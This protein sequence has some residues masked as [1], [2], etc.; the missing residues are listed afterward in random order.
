MA[1]PRPPAGS[2]AD[3]AM[4]ESRNVSEE[5]VRL[6][7]SG[8]S[9]VAAWNEW[10][11]GNRDVRLNLTGVR[12]AGARLSGAV[13][14]SADLR[15]ADQTGARVTGANLR[16]ADLSQTCLRGAN[17]G[18]SDFHGARLL[19]AD[20][21]EARLRGARFTGADL[22]YAKLGDAFLAGADLGD[23]RLAYANLAGANLAYANLSQCVLVETKLERSVLDGCR[24]Y[25]ASV[26]NVTGVPAS[27]AGLRITEGRP[28]EPEVT[29]DDLEVAQF[30]YLLLNNA[31]LRNV[32][33]TVG[34]KAVLLL[35]RFTDA[36]KAV[37]EGLHAE[38]R[39]R[40]YLPILFTF[41]RPADRD[42]T[43]TV[44]TLA[45]M[46]R[47]VIADLT[48]AASVQQELTAIVAAL[49]SVVVKP[50]IVRGQY[51]WSMFVD[52]QRRGAVLAPHVYDSPASLLAELPDRVIDPADQ[53]AR[54][55]RAEMEQLYAEA[56]AR[57][58]QVTAEQPEP[59]SQ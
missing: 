55:L 36:R 11:R 21:T 48:D 23:A 25:G 52:L 27:Q 58:R 3:S 37:L 43:E 1:S 30:V 18:G 40:G 56:A 59:N 4:A 51:E 29:V 20:F 42:I 19:A 13:L 35:G 14:A 10:R 34:R 2:I 57:R 9:G 6:L 47:F 41:D 31:K 53:K 46:A 32:I 54:A 28:G 50:I 45:G 44:V 26:W 17:L 22:A 33:D 8:P 12:L 39:R 15:Y 49:P 16:Y 24:V 5:H 7:R 38:L